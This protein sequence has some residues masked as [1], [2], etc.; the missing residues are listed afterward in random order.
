MLCPVLSIIFSLTEDGQP[1]YNW[2]TSH[3]VLG[4]IQQK[5]LCAWSR[6]NSSCHEIWEYRC[7]INRCGSAASASSPPQTSAA[8][9]EAGN[10]R[11]NPA[12]T[13]VLLSFNCVSFPALALIL[14]K[15]LW[16]N[17]QKIWSLYLK[18]L[19]P[20][21]GSLNSCTL[22]KH[23]NIRCRFSHFF[24]PLQLSH[25]IRTALHWFI[26]SCLTSFSCGSSQK[27]LAGWE[28]LLSPGCNLA[29]KFIPAVPSS[30]HWTLV[31]I[32]PSVP[33]LLR[34]QD[35]CFFLLKIYTYIHI[36]VKLTHSFPS[37]S[38]FFYLFIYFFCCI[39]FMF[40]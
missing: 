8:E 36:Y 25:C 40:H 35:I 30:N 15:A 1:A 9:R 16:H 27:D 34:D 14:K 24:S 19:V 20:S 6:S 17:W 37:C 10:G 2:S 3:H 5:C 39:D 26:S 18:G 21:R 31:K 23:L 4:L 22:I 28:A 32:V 13:A 33:L 11:R 12:G 38:P 29:I 7:D